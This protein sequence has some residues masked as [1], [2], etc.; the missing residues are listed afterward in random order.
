MVFDESEELVGFE[1]ECI[2]SM[3]KNMHSRSYVN[4]QRRRDNIIVIGDNLGDIRMSDG[5]VF[6]NQIS[7]GLLNDR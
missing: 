4:R 7:I 6:Q 2:T 3:N 1:G 5:V